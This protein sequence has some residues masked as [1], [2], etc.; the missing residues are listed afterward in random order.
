MW[1]NGGAGDLT[2]Y[3]WNTPPCHWSKPGV[4]FKAFTWLDSAFQKELLKYRKEQEL[5]SLD[6]IHFYKDSRRCK[7]AI[8]TPLRSASVW[9]MATK[10]GLKVGGWLGLKTLFQGEWILNLCPE[11][12]AFPGPA[13]FYLIIALAL[14]IWRVLSLFVYSPRLSKDTAHWSMISIWISDFVVQLA[15]QVPS[16]SM[17]C[18]WLRFSETSLL[19]VIWSCG[20]TVS[21]FEPWAH[22]RSRS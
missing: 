3:R 16:Y 11:R 1:N 9:Y 2:S 21:H 19:D 12:V 13:R 7:T 20:D 17:M 10:S 6:L 18:D 22:H 8:M 14:P 5:A 4:S 15:L